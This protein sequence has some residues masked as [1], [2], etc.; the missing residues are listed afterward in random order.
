MLLF[1]ELNFLQGELAHRLVKRLYGLTNKRDAPEQIGRRYRR[2]S[3][4]DVLPCDPSQV[5]AV[6][7]E[8][9]SM[10]DDVDNSPELHHTITNS[11]NN[12]V[13]LASF[14][15]SNA[16]DPAAKVGKHAPP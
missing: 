16:R 14:S 5:D 13:D 6:R 2:E 12:P 4:F 7:T 15:G 3:H 8:H 10:C 1:S 11:R 9:V